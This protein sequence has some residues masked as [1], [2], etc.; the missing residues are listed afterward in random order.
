M[1]ACSGLLLFA[2]VLGTSHGGAWLVA[3]LAISMAIGAAVPGYGPIQLVY[4]YALRQ[5]G[6]V[7]PDVRQ[8]EPAPHRFAQ[9][10]GAVVLS[11]SAIALF[12]GVAWLGWLLGAIVV[13]LALANLVF[14]FCTGC[15]IFLQLRRAGLFS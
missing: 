4:R 11:A 13:A 7:K 6:L 14:G 3:A 1:P 8:E 2:F 12:A 5:T 9:A 10:V 15:F